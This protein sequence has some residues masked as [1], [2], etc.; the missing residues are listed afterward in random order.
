MTVDETQ[1]EVQKIADIVDVL[2][3]GG[4]APVGYSEMPLS[5]REALAKVVVNLANLDM[6]IDGK[7][8]PA[9]DRGMFFAEVLFTIFL[10]GR[11]YGR[12]E[13]EEGAQAILS[14][15]PMAPCDRCLD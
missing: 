8:V 4:Q 1:A 7:E 15:I 13:K 2:F 5:I 6:K 3:D 11:R 12:L 9:N 10:M 14:K